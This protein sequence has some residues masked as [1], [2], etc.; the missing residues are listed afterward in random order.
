MAETSIAIQHGAVRGAVTGGL[1][2]FKGIPYAAAPV[3]PNR[4]RPPQP[5]EPWA[6]VRNAV[7]FG[8][9][10][11][12]APYAPP[13]D[14]LIPEV[15][16]PGDEYLNLNVWTPETTGRRPVLVWIHGGAFVNGSG[17]AYDGSAFA[18][19]GVVCVTLNYRLGA[20]G[21]L[22]LGENSNLGLLDQIAAL[23]WVQDN[24]EAFG[25]DPGQVTVFGESA[26]AMSIGTLLGMP[27]ARGL[28]RRAILQSG[29]A[30]HSVTPST[31][32]LI[33][34]H[35]AEQLR[36][37]PTADGF[38]NAPISEL[39]A[40]SQQLRATISAQPDAAL[41]GEAATNLLPF[42]PV[43]D[44]VTLPG[45]PIGNLAPDVDIMVGSNADEFR[46]YLVPSGLWPHID[47]TAL[48]AMLDRYELDDSAVAA[49]RAQRPDAEANELFAAIVTDW[50]F[51]IPA[52]RLAEASRKAYMYEFAWQ[53]PTFRGELGA[54]HAAEIPFVFDALDSKAF[55]GLI[56]DHPPQYLADELHS[57][58]VSF[59]TNGNPGWFG[60][61]E[62][63]RSTMRFDLESEIVMDPGAG[64]RAVW[65]GKR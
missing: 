2:A 7:E 15:D 1:L 35:L 60:Y 54:C 28:F 41:W 58:W 36:V 45:P 24:I 40:A 32:R 25:G 56:G 26:G 11:P 18:R 65:E 16:I 23:Q 48:R 34:R 49:Y 14:A 29:A 61:Q 22:Y 44:G 57:A 55:T 19:D 64:E 63:S 4:F 33:T 12:K 10:A 39:V 9:T 31:G 59:A 46:L 6:G 20:D 43:I 53:P 21:F 30:H 51:R 3:G 37:R 47:E 42:A 8:P 50:V 5:V 13:L 27:A 52:I 62:G 17:S 38:A